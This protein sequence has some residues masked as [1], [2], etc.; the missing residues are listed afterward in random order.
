M[1]VTS[2]SAWKQSR[3]TELDGVTHLLL[4]WFPRAT[5][6]ISH[7]RGPDG[8]CVGEWILVYGHVHIQE[9]YGGLG[10]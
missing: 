3:L 8:V 9:T 6:E 7:G 2:N 1:S 5:G 4:D 10:A